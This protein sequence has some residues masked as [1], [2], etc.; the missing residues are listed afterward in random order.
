MTERKGSMSDKKTRSH[1]AQKVIERM[2]KKLN[3]QITGSL[4]ACVHC[5]TAEVLAVRP[6]GKWMVRFFSAFDLSTRPT[7]IV[8]FG[9]APAA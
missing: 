3:R 2:G 5:G 4:L 8:R 6:T 1:K 9:C 7:F